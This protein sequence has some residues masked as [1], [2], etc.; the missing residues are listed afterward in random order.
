MAFISAL[1][2]LALLG[3]IASSLHNA[4]TEPSHREAAMLTF[5]VCASGMSFAGVSGA[6]WGVVLGV[7]L[8]KMQT[9]KDR[10]A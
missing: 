8:Q 1:A 4:L 9:R 5:L 3:T 2:G 7:V 10:P 6:F